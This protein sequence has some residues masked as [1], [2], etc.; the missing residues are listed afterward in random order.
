MLIYL[1]SYPRSGNTWSRHLI[2]HYFG[3]RSASVYHEPNGAPNLTYR[4]DG[5]FELFSYYQPTHTPTVSLPMLVNNCGAVLSEGL[6]QQLADSSVCFFLKTHERPF[7][8]YLPGEYVVHLVREPGAVFWS[9]FNYL[10]KN[11]SQ[12]TASLTLDQVIAGKVGFGLWSDHT[13]AWLKARAQMP[14]R[15]LLCS[16][17]QLSQQETHICDS[18]ALMSHLDYPRGLPPLPPLAHWH[19]KAPTLYRK[20]GVSHW[21]E[22]FTSAQLHRIYQLHHQAI[23]QLGYD[24]HAYRQPLLKRLRQLW[25]PVLRDWMNL[26]EHS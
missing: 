15:F 11:E 8:R 17:E 3:Y 10:R 19:Q 7:E 24:V 18:I 22:H 25:Q 12:K 20:E 14:E 6:R 4:E 23:E 13:R 1:S 16:Y 9:Y 5:S 26:R 2:R 21:Y